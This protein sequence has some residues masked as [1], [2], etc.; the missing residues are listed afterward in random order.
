[1]SDG[2]IT[3]DAKP[4]K[5]GVYA[6]RYLHTY[7]G[8]TEEFVRDGFAWWH[9]KFKRWGRVSFYSAGARRLMHTAESIY[10]T[11]QD[12]SWKVIS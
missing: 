1:M 12:L 5:P 4:T 3:A 11:K 7:T 2:Y 10:H 8:E 9:G 6:V